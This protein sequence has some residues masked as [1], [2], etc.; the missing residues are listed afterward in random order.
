MAIRGAKT[1]VK[2]KVS[3]IE[4]L[5]KYRGVSEAKFAE[6]RDLLAYKAITKDD[7]HFLVLKEEADGYADLL[8][9]RGQGVGT[10]SYNEQQNII[11]GFH[12]FLS[13]A[14]EDMKIIIS[15][16]P[17]DTSH[18]RRFW[19]QRYT[20]VAD[21]LKQATNQRRRQ[22]LQTQL[23][24]ISSRQRQNVAVEKALVSEEFILVIFGKRKIDLRNEREAVIAWGGK[25]LVME[26]LP[27]EKKEEILTRINNLNTR[28]K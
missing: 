7:D 26:T 8:S 27:L 24:Y 23:R 22:Q 12:H 10:M 25:A 21:Q 2:K 1:Q 19:G 15:P 4:K 5:K 9:I 3:P 20:T 14:L 11:E 18:Q 28:V 16:F 13:A 6:M 17:V